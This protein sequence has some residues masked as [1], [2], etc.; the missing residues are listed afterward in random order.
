MT[1]AAEAVQSKLSGRKGGGSANHVI[2]AMESKH[3]GGPGAAAAAVVVGG[4]KLS[5]RSSTDMHHSSRFTVQYCVPVSTVRA[6]GTTSPH[7]RRAGD[8]RGAQIASSLAV[9]INSLTQACNG[10]GMAWN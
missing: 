9:S 5:R 2:I 7:P 10:S 4:D 3:K 1:P 8:L 6:S